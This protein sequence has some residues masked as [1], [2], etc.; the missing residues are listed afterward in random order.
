MQS[1]RWNHSAT[2]LSDHRVLVIGGMDRLL[3]IPPGTIPSTGLDTAELFDPVSDAWSPALSMRYT[4][5]SPT[6]TLLLDGRVLVVGD[7]GVN[8]QTAEFFDPAVNKWSFSRAPAAG[9][10]GHVAVRLRS[11]AVLVAGGL[12]ETSA[13]VF[14][15]HR[16]IWITAGRLAEIR[17]GATATLLN[18]GEVLVAGGFGN[19]STPWASAELFDPLGTSVGAVRSNRSAPAPVAWAALLV[20][21]LLLLGLALWLRRSRLVRQWQANETWID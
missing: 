18:D 15:W 3:D 16:N 21:P 11:G 9:R 1:P 2:L 13:E 20:I 7:N 12:R 14:D 17:S 10:A 4:R 8:E 5:I 6:S 19:Q